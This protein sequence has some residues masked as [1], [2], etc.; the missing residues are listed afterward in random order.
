M[1]TFIGR[2]PAQRLAIL[3]AVA[4]QIGATFLPQLGLG[5]PIGERSDSVRTLITPAG[6]AFSIWGPLFFGSAVFAVWQALPAQRD[7]ALVARTGWW[8]ALALAAQG[9]WATYTQFA[10]LTFVSVLIIATSLAAL[11]AILRMLVRHEP[12]FTPG[13]RWIV[14]LVFSAL[15]AWLT[16]ATIVNVSASLV[17]QGVGGG[18]EHPGIT[19]LIVLVGGAIATLAVARS[20]GNPWYATV[21][22]WAL[23]AIALRGDAQSGIVAVACVVAALLVVSAMVLGLRIRAHRARWLGTG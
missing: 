22:C 19:A 13:E 20:K 4:W 17:Y 16:A 5:E 18:M 11:L 7:N 3:L 10:N 8:A 6:W 1:S 14:A 12:A 9:A 2:P 23:A 21:F 15:A